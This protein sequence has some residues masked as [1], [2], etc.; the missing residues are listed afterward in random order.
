MKGKIE[1]TRRF[2]R[3]GGGDAEESRA[4][5]MAPLVGTS[6]VDP[7]VCDIPPLSK[8][9]ESSFMSPRGGVNR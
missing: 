5:G 4:G 7:P 2:E 6:K 1:K 3:G 9:G 8:D